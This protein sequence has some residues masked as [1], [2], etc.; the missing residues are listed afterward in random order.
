MKLMARWFACAMTALM[1]LPQTAGAQQEQCREYSY[2][3]Y[4]GG[5]PRVWYP[6]MQEACVAAAPLVT[7]NS[8]NDEQ[9][10]TY[11]TFK[12]V[13]PPG[14]P[15]EGYC[16]LIWN[17]RTYTGNPYTDGWSNWSASDV[18]FG[19]HSR[20]ASCPATIE[21]LGPSRT[22]ALPAGPVLPLIARITQQGG[23]AANKGLTLTLQREGGEPTTFN[24]VTDAAGDFKFIYVPPY[25][26]TVDRLT[27]TCVDCSNT[28]VKVITV[29]ACDSCSASG[30]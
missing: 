16:V 26:A 29:E 28:A 6:T 30:Q 1:L 11:F 21:L 4:N 7:E 23:L 13:V 24:G 8:A 9:H 5:P 12:E 14:R 22:K 3:A 20:P 19:G 27:A 10:Q 2:Y 18:M 17:R 15:Y 25:R